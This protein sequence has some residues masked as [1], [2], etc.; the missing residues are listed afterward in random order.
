M[1]S[2]IEAVGSFIA[3]DQLTNAIDRHASG[4]I[5]IPELTQAEDEAVREIVERQLAVGVPYITSGE[6][7]R[8]HWDKDFWFGLNGITCERVDT[9]HAYMPVEARRDLVRITGRIAFN[10]EHPF[11]R[12]FSFLHDAVGGRA[13]CRECLPSPADLLMS[14]FSLSDGHPER[15]YESVE[16]LVN[17]IALAY[18]LTAMHIHS[19]GCRSLQFDD[20]A[21]GRLCDATFTKRLLQG[22]V[23]IMQLHKLVVE[24]INRSVAGLPADM[25]RSIYLSGGDRVVPEWEFIR[26]PDNIMPQ[27]LAT[28]DVDKFFLP[29]NVSQDY[30]LEILR[31][32]PAGKKVVLGVADAHSPYPDDE[33]LIAV[34]IGH[35]RRYIP[36]DCLSISPRTGFK[37]SS[38]STR[39]ITFEDQWNKL[40]WLGAIR[41]PD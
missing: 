16:V 12:D 15:M 34:A 33:A 20:T 2:S 8:K 11:F 9:G 22:G 1:T 38:Y 5:G 13:H 37:C 30:P 3:P 40:A 36:A 19:L 27:A 4:A 25:E 24:V 23:D 32:V 17:D 10:P 28:L 6:L 35:A 14:V 41:L 26:Y 31:H 29:F 7:R 21:C 39:G 18:R